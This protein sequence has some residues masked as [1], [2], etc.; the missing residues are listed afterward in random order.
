MPYLDGTRHKALTGFALATSAQLPGP[1]RG[2]A[3]SLLD[4]NTAPGEARP[5]DALELAVR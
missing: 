4:G 2:K 1:C 5:A 3:R